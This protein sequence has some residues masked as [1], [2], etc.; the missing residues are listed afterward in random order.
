MRLYKELTRE[1]HNNISNLINE[2]GAYILIFG[3]IIL[4]GSIFFTFMF[5]ND[6]ILI[7]SIIGVIVF[8]I[9]Y[10]MALNLLTRAKQLEYESLINL[11]LTYTEKLVKNNELTLVNYNLEQIISL[12]NNKNNYHNNYKRRKE[13]TH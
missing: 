4:I 6:L 11:Q 5:W 1:S 8:L 7:P 3:C 9:S 13:N 12:L 10:I 2:T